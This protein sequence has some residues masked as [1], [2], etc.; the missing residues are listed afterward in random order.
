MYI[1]HVRESVGSW[2]LTPL[3]LLKLNFA[4]HKNCAA[5]ESQ[6]CNCRCI[7]VSDYKVCVES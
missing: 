6:E 7:A 4:E 2:N 3:F 5:Q 1:R